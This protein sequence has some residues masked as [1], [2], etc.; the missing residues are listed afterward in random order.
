VSLA[1][2]IASAILGAWPAS[3]LAAT[4]PSPGLA[5]RF[6]AL[7]AA[8]GS[9][10]AVTCTNGTIT[11]NVGSSGPAA[12]VALS[13]CP[14][15]GSI[16]APV[17]AQVI[18]DFNTAY[19]AY[20]PIPCDAVLTGTL[21]GVILGP[22]VYCFDA[23]ATLTG[24]LTLSGP[25]TGTWIFKI[26]TSGTG[27]LTGTGFTVVMAGGG[28]AC[29]VDWQVA[30]AATMTDSNFIGTV[31]TGADISLTRGTFIGN[32]L[33]T[34]GV[35]ITG[36]AVTGCPPPPTADIA[37]TKTVDDPTP[38]LDSNVTFTVTAT[39]NGPDNATGVQ[40][41][42][43]LPAGL[44]FVSATPS[45]GT[46]TAGTGVWDIGPLAN[47]ANSTLSIVPTVTSTARL[48]NTATKTA[49]DQIDPVTGNDT[50]SASVTALGADIA[51]T[52]TVDNPTP[53]LGSN[54]TF[55]ITAT[56]NGPGNATGVQVT[57]LLPAGLSLVSA[58][59]SLGAY[60]A[61][62][63]IWDIGPLANAASD[64]LSI[65]ATVTSTAGLTNTATKTAEDQLDPVAANNRAT[66]MVTALGADIA[67]T[68]T[69]DNPTPSLGTNVTFTITATNNGPGDATGVQ[70]T[71]LLPSGLT[72]VSA[73]NTTGT[74]S[75][76]TGVWDIGPLANSAS[77]TLSI[78]ATVTSTATLTNTATKTA[79]DQVDP[80]NSNDTASATA[81]ALGADI[82]ITKT[83]DKPTPNL[84]SNVTFTVTATN[85]GPS[86]AT[87]VQVSD[88]LPAGL[89]LVSA[90]PSVGAYGAL[91]GIWTVGAL[92]NGA[93][94]TLAIVGTVTSTTAVT[95]TATKTAEDQRDPVPGND[96]ASAT[97]I[98]ISAD[99]A[100]TKT[101]DNPTPNLGSNV[102][103]TITA[104]DNG[105][106]NATGVQVTD[107]LPPGLSLV[108]ATTATGS[109]NSGTG[110]WIIGP[111]A[112]GS[113]AT[114]AIIATLTS[115][116]AVTNTATKAA[117]D[118]V[119]PVGANNRATATVTALGADI[120]ITKTVD[121]PTPNLG[122]NVTF[123]VTAT[124]NGPG[125]ATGVQVTD[126]LPAGLSLVSATPSVGAYSAV[127]GIWSIGPL[128]GGG[129]AT[130][131]ISATVTSA[132]PAT[133]TATRTA[134]DELDPVPANDSASVTIIPIS[135]DIAITKTVDNPTPNLGSNVTFT[136]TTT[137]NGPSN[138]TGV[139]VTDLLPAGLTF[140]SAA[141]ATGSYNSGTGIWNIG[142]LANGANASLSIVATATSTAIV[143]NTAT[144][145][146]EVQP[147]LQTIN[148]SASVTVTA[149]APDPV[150][151][152]LPNTSAPEVIAG[153][154]GAFAPE[155]NAGLVLA[156]VAMLAGL[157]VLALADIRHR[158]TRPRRRHS[159]G[160]LAIGV[161]AVVLNLAFSSFSLGELIPNPSPPGGPLA[162]VTPL[163]GS[164]VVSVV[165]PSAPRS[166]AFHVV[167]GPITPT[168]LR[169]PS[170]GVDTSIGA[171]GLRVDGS[172]DI[173]DNLWTLSWLASSPRPGQAGN[174]VMAGHRGVGTP[175]LFS[176]LEN[177]RPGA[178]IYVSDAAG[179]E[180]IYVVTRLASRD[181]SRST[182]VAVFG[183]A[184]A[185]Q[186][187]LV[188]CFGQ[189][190]ESA[191]TYDHRLLVF[192][193][194][195]PLI[196]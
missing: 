149:Q 36:T 156:V 103:F 55:T 72:F 104:T 117:E 159:P 82:A 11:G 120:A 175:A 61:L 114:L 16:T 125:N 190:I 177:L 162:P 42:D 78:L 29:N 132:S 144:K 122:S 91:T 172:M 22:G 113:S 27:A 69:V 68:K 44:S 163:I 130:L 51:L 141:T 57:D 93:N 184:G 48:T 1:I 137:N 196:T 108:S 140:V 38:S 88:L 5:Q 13:S 87:G 30:Q 193:T 150:L 157:G 39:N 86:N 168:R 92:A 41:T 169:I 126:L 145:T 25:L 185:A 171:V 89:S 129:S 14:I 107:L 19:V 37:I 10:G 64:T 118:Q 49:E 33:A 2:L 32:A 95:N 191:R 138:A 12:S 116:S 6:A 23:A 186:L 7:S 26:G 79:E 84:G 151:P 20:G 47:G 63:G 153:A 166:Q 134:E 146:A 124:N 99:I 85:D 75:S 195:L 53:S 135:A 180:L 46:Y 183:P 123:T 131:A 54:V 90:T 143:T 96:T 94:A 170:I 65:V 9:G 100:I 8:P 181:L 106:S 173:P 161:L 119:D 58:T 111:L 160:R 127:T 136:V 81:T 15:S 154:P 101:V 59:P 102:T 74:Y 28:L 109:Y 60:S 43:L 35:T 31:L 56:N 62:S 17:S 70:V 97:L 121:N 167:A 182:Q 189:Y 187:V 174:V 34:A 76:G 50:A 112:N 147:D 52:K 40:V 67:I 80:V 105:P 142:P 24:T 98:P 139:Q 194:L 4:V 179:N 66:A 155:N 178:K 152:G 188:T 165:P 83:V 77:A 164:K 176:H 115:T 148:D 128:A 21:S 18:T 3:A 71:D 192:S 73:A 110:I 158:R 45:A 133:N